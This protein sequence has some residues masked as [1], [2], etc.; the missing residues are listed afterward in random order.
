MN[1]Q[2]RPEAITSEEALSEEAMKKRWLDEIA[3][4]RY[5]AFIAFRR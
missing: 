2:D 1:R 4:S 5:L 3:L